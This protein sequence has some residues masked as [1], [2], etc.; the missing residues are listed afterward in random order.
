MIIYISNHLLFKIYQNYNHSFNIFSFI[1]N[2]TL[3][4]ILFFF[5]INIKNILKTIY[6]VLYQLR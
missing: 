4:Q 1:Y 3:K 2:L 6:I 5:K